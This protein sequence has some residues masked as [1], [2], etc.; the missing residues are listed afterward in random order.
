MP[1][2]RVK[3]W[4]RSAQYFRWRTGRSKQRCM[5]TSCF[6]VF[7]RIFPDVLDRFSQ[8]F[9]HMKALYMPMMEQ[10]FIFPFVKGRY[11]GNQ[12][13]SKNRPISFVAL[14]FWNRLQYQ[15]LNRMSFSTLYT[16]LVIFGPVTPEIERVT[17]ASCWIV[18]RDSKNYYYYYYYY[19]YKWKD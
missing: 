1:L 4:W 12:L 9:H 5:F 11:H 8:S 2:Y 14:P 7:R 13:K 16:I 17:T 15:I 19:Y 6:D 3:F 10:Y 18:G